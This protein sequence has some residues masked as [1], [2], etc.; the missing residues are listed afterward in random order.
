MVEKSHLTALMSPEGKRYQ[1]RIRRR[2]STEPI[3]VRGSGKSGINP[4][5]VPL[6]AVSMEAIIGIRVTAAAKEANKEKVTV[7]A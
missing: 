5:E 4:L 2:R 7:N 6:L 3:F 1:R